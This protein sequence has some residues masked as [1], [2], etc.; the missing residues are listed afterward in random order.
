MQPFLEMG[1][2]FNKTV[3]QEVKPHAAG[4]RELCLSV[5]PHP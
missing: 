4:G 1:A 3:D 5:N 2:D